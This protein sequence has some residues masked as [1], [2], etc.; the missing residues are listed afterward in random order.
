MWD[1]LTGIAVFAE[2]ENARVQ[3]ITADALRSRLEATIG[4]S[5]PQF[6]PEDIAIKAMHA[7]MGD[8]P[9]GARIGVVKQMLAAAMYA[10][11][12]FV[13]YLTQASQ[14]LG[15]EA[16]SAREELTGKPS[17]EDSK[18]DYLRTSKFAPAILRRYFEKKHQ[19]RARIK[20]VGQERALMLDVLGKLY[21][22]IAQVVVEIG[23]EFRGVSVDDIFRLTEINHYFSGKWNGTGRNLTFTDDAVRPYGTRLQQLVQRIWD[24]GHKPDTPEPLSATQLFPKWY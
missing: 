22:E 23:S 8:S 11:D 18:F 4:K 6:S 15:A 16:I 2:T 9:Y 19:E 20:Q 1:N 3:D 21:H 5:F 17:P 7:Y 12:Q 24:A 14:R 10:P 13:L